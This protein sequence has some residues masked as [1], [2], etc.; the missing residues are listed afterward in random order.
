MKKLL[1]LLAVLSIQLISSC[2]AVKEKDV[3]GT[4]NA[5]FLR[6]RDTLI[7]NQNHTYVYR[8]QNLIH[9][10]SWELKGSSLYFNN[11]KFSTNGDINTWVADVKL[12]DNDVRIMYAE[13]D[14]CYYKKIK[15]ANLRTAATK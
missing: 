13:E 4:Y 10:G 14:G 8:D 7:V 15:K 2:K 1:F 11:F 6:A 5:A 3:V 9:T 12:Q